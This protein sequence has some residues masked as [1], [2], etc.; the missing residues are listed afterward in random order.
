MVDDR[1]LSKFGKKSGLR[2]RE[3][4][5]WQD[6]WPS[7]AEGG[8]FPMNKLEFTEREPCVCERAWCLEKVTRKSLFASKLT[9]WRSIRGP[10]LIMEMTV[11]EKRGDI[12]S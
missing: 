1:Q 3:V 9:G 8:P 11:R 2:R 5:K 4:W 6:V 12:A 10:R 7:R